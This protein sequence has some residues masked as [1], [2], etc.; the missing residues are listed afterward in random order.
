MRA[1]LT[2]SRRQPLAACV[3]AVFGL[4]APAAMAAPTTCLPSLVVNTCG[5][6]SANACQN[7]LRV[8]AENAQS[9]DTIDLTQ[10]P[11]GCS[12]ISLET[13]ANGPIVL[14]Q[15]SVT[16]NGPGTNALTVQGRYYSAS[17]G[18]GY[19][20]P[21]S[22]VFTH[23][24]TGTLTMNNFTVSYG[25][26]ATTGGSPALG[27]CIASSGTLYLYK[28]NV[29][30]CSA[31]GS[32]AAK[33]GALFAAQDLYFIDGILGGSPATGNVATVTLSTESVYGGGAYAAGK[34]A[35]VNSTVSYNQVSGPSPFA[36]GGG[37][38]GNGNLFVKYSTISNNTA[39]Q[40]G[41]VFAVSNAS[42]ATLGIYNSTISGNTAHAYAGVWTRTGHVNISNSTISAN[43]AQSKK[44]AGLQLPTLYIQAIAIQ[45]SIIAQNYV[46]ATEADVYGYGTARSISGTNNL[47]G[48]V[49]SSSSANFSSPPLS[50]C[51]LLGPLRNNGGPTQTHALLSHSPAIDAGNNI[52]NNWNQDQRGLADGP[53]PPYPYPRVSGSAADIGAY[54]VQQD[55]IV[56]NAGFDGCASLPP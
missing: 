31:N 30:S 6:A 46:G 37:L 42:S 52:A 41:G 16:I 49:G 45:S 35:V 12:T 40:A 10:L 4:A 23:T 39:Y 21:A 15:S 48:V 34:L 17:C 18:P 5:D 50:K 25:N 43:V 44:G 22:R 19:C 36:S 28:V 24:G 20:A 55:D 53:S 3:A 51:P 56:F 33:G 54:E 2:S 14:A 47:V 26:V 8:A 29:H 32:G 1:R 27:G 7:T 13:A 11:L 38:M 9:G